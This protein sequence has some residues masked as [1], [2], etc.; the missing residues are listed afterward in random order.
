MGLRKFGRKQSVLW[1]TLKAFFHPPTIMAARKLDHAWE[2]V[3]RYSHR[4]PNPP[5]FEAR[6]E[7]LEIL[8]RK[9]RLLSAPWL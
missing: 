4:G 5:P 7:A 2:Y 9:C 3:Y 1:R 6:I 8:S